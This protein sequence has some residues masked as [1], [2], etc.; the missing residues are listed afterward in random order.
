MAYADYFQ[1]VDG[2]IVAQEVIFGQM[3]LL[4]QIGALPAS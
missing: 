3:E 1:V 4:G 2:K